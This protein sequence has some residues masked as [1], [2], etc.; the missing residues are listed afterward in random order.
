MAR[1]LR[2]GLSAGPGG[3][4]RRRGKGAAGI[5]LPVLLRRGRRLGLIAGANERVADLIGVEQF[6][7]AG[8]QDEFAEH[9]LLIGPELVGPGLQGGE[10]E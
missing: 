6:M 9:E 8:F 2:P 5:G 1:G 10:I 3:R 7:D 4:W